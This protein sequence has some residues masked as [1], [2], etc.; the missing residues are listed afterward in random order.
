MNNQVVCFRVFNPLN[1]Q[2]INKF[3]LKHKRPN[4]EIFEKERSGKMYK[5]NIEKTEKFIEDHGSFPCELF[6][7]RNDIE[8]QKSSH[9]IIT[10]KFI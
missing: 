10:I 7:I 1:L 4:I 8:H 9:N 3:A 6:L 5:I 2:K